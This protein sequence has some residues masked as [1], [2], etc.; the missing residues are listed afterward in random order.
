MP[1][2][3][4]DIRAARARVDETQSQFAQ[5]FGVDRSTVASWE[6][7]GLP[8][9]GT[10]PTLIEQTIRDIAGKQ[11]KSDGGGDVVDG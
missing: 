9:K 2:S 8:R 11:E 6:K 10:A 5:R 4:A 1:V 7:R 3:A